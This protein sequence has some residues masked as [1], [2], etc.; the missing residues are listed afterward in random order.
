MKALV[1][2][3]NALVGF[4]GPGLLSLAFLFLLW[5]LL[6]HDDF[7]L[8]LARYLEDWPVGEA[9]ALVVVP[10]AMKIAVR[11]SDVPLWE[12][13]IW[14]PAVLLVLGGIGGFIRFLRATWLYVLVKAAPVLF[15]KPTDP[16][17][18]FGCLT[19]IV[20]AILFVILGAVF[21]NRPYEWPIGTLIV[22]HLDQPDMYTANMTAFG[23]FYFGA[24]AIL[25]V[26]LRRSWAQP[27]IV[28]SSGEHVAP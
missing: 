28:K 8:N 19:S 1:P 4:L 2:T 11:K 18:A 9:I 26:L 7:A 17:A 22:P 12:R 10:Y 5:G 15:T 25:E 27:D 3:T 6:N 21:M 24:A 20:G 13:I 23:M 14:L 16:Q